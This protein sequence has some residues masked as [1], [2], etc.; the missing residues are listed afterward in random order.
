MNNKYGLSSVL[1]D[2]NSIELI[3]R[4]LKSY[5]LRARCLVFEI[6]GAVC[7]MPGGHLRVLNSIDS[8]REQENLDYESIVAS[9]RTAWS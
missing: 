1:A 5:S 6:L 7:L 8:D 9:T 3:S 2:E 4:S